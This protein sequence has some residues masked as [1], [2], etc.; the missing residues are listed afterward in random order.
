MSSSRLLGPPRRRQRLG[1]RGLLVEELGAPVPDPA[2]LDED[3]LAARRK[4]VGQHPL[5]ALE[6]REPR[7]HAVELLAR[8]PGAPT[9]TPPRAAASSSDSAAAWISG[10]TTSSRHPKRATAPMSC[11]ERWS[12][13]ANAVSRSTSSPH[14]SMRTGASAVEGNTSTIPPRT[15]NSPAVLDLVLAAVPPG[16]QLGEERA[17]VDLLARPDDDRRGPVGGPEPL[18]QRADRRDDHPRAAPAAC[19]RA[20]RVSACRTARRRPIVSISGLT[21]SKGR[22]SHAGRT[23]TGP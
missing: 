4:Q 7:L 20:R 22:V 14:R 2:G 6:E 17:D 21:R 18:E 12:L 13:T 15:A 5:G 11:S 8:A 10:V 3:H 9:P 16:H 1:Q 23:V 19:R